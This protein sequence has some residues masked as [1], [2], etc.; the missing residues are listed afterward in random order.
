MRS[1]CCYGV[2]A[3]LLLVI[4]M[5]GHAAWRS[6]G[7]FVA[8]IK[9][10]AVDKTNP[11]SIYAATSAGG[12]WRSDDAGQT[13]TLPGERDGEP[14]RPVDRSGSRKSRDPLGRHRGPRG[15]RSLALSRPRQDLGE[16]A[17]RPIRLRCGTA[18]RVRSVQPPPHLCPLHQ[19]PLQERRRRKD[20]AELP[21]SRPGRLHL[22]HPSPEPE[23]RLRRR[24]RFRA[25]PEPQPGRRE[26]LAPVRRRASQGQQHQA[27][28]HL[29]GEPVHTPRLLRI[30]PPAPEHGWRGDLG[31]TGA[32]P[33]RHG[34]NLRSRDRS[35]RSADVT[36]GDETGPAQ[37]HR[38]RRD[39]EVSRSGPRRLPVPRT[40]LPSP[41]RK[42][43]STPVRPGPGFSRAS[44]AVKPLRRSARAWPPAGRRRSTRRRPARGPIFA[45]LSVGLFRMD[46]PASWTEIQ[47]PFSPGETAKIDGIVFDR[48]SPKRIY[49][50]KA[51]S[52][53]RSDDAGRSWSKGR[54]SAAEHE[55]HAPGQVQRTPVQEPRAGSR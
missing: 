46:G 33:A 2:L 26:D 21:R 47:A 41:A 45:Q 49:A 44:T 52:W 30:R 36:G 32:G 42:V 54:G 22:R 8:A 12:V 48:D 15:L 40:R 1:R 35:A 7:P 9:D 14:Q 28:A 20:V 31:R 43:S 37:E 38:R 6:E 27:P 5:L 19:S 18:D 17:G 25:Q 50:H 23:H 34:R 24:A 11:D 51:S 13:W 10:V 16:R 29:R 55:E 53:W 39:L 4:P 3:A